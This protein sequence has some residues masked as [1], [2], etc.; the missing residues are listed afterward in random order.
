MRAQTR[1][2]PPI[3]QTRKRRPQPAWVNGTSPSQKRSRRQTPAFSAGSSFPRQQRLFLN[4]T[5]GIIDLDDATKEKVK[6]Y[7]T[8]EVSLSKL[9]GRKS[10]KF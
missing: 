2:S 9:A 1:R 5:L 8:I 7:L 10:R 6:L 4:Q 3:R